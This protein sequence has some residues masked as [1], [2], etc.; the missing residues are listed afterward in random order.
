MCEFGMA[1]KYVRANIL[2]LTGYVPGEQPSPQ[3]KAVKLNTNE[4]PYRASE[5]VYDAINRV[6]QVGLSRYPDPHATEFRN[7]AAQKFNIEP[8]MVLCGN[9]SDELFTLLM[10]TFV[11]YGDF[12]QVP[13]PTYS[14]YETI[15]EALGARCVLTRF[16]DDWSLPD[17]F[18]SEDRRVRLV[19]LPNPNSPSGTLLPK[20]RILEI[21]E[22]L[23]CPLVVDEAYADFADSSCIDL[24]GRC[25]RIIVTRSLSKSYSLAGLRFGY[26]VAAPELV[27][28]VCKIK[29]S[30][31]CDS[32]SI[33]AATAAISDDSWLV[34]NRKKILA[35]RNRLTKEMRNLNFFVPDSSA[36]F[37]WNVHFQRS[38]RSIYNHLY[39]QGIIVRLMD[40]KYWDGGL[41]ISVGTDEQIDQC[42]SSIRRF[43]NGMG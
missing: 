29:D 43:V 19:F 40:Y 34:E 5:A 37:T 15:A 35:T 41:R 18:Y 10:R 12:I 9:G 17:K 20:E 22:N 13:Y 7:A 33:A 21:A 8:N 4:N 27:G 1:S 36:N 11:G 28:Q 24:I 14:L 30:Y 25:E 26:L 3:S 23:P 6:V 32:I 39:N 2:F 42:I 38:A 31:N 16:N